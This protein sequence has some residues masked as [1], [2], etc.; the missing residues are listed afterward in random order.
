MKKKIISLILCLLCIYNS[1][2]F[3]QI[4]VEQVTQVAKN[5]LQERNIDKE[6]SLFNI[7]LEDV[8]QKNGAN[9]LYILNLGNKEGFFVLSASEFVAPIVGY[10]FDNEFQWQPAIRYYLDA[11][12][13][14]I[15]FE[16]KSKATPDA[17]VSNQWKHYLQEP[18]VS[19]KSRGVIVPPLITSTWNQNI[20]Y[21]TYC[22]W[23][24]RAMQ[25]FDGRVPNG[26][27]ALATAQLMNYWRHPEKG[28]GT[29]SYVHYRYGTQSANF[30]NQYYWDAMCDKPT[31]Y[32]NEIS[33]LA[34]HLG[35]AVSMNYAP[36]GS[37]A[38]TKK[39][40]EA[41]RDHFNYTDFLIW[42]AD[43]G[44]NKLSNELDSLRP[45]LMD[46]CNAAGCHAFLVDGY[47]EIDSSGFRFHFN[48]GWG[49]SADGYYSQTNQLYS[50]GYTYL[51]L[52]P[53][54]NYPV[55][56]QTYKRQTAT[57]GY[58][59]NG[60]TNKPY[61]SAP[62]CSW[63][64]AAP[65]VKEYT[66]SFS[67][68]ETQENIDVVTIYNGPTKNS[69]VAQSFSGTTLPTQKVK[70]VADSVL[71]TFTTFDATSQNTTHRG[72]L[73]NYSTDKPQQK[74]DRLTYL[75]T[76]NGYISS[77]NLADEKYTPWTSCTWNITPE[78]GSGFYGIF[79]NFDLAI[80]DFVD[81]Y[82]ANTPNPTFWKRYDRNTRPVIG[83][84]F[85][86]PFSK[87]QIKFISDNFEEG[88]GFKFQYLSLLGVDE[89]S[90]LDNLS[91][92]PNPASD[93]IN[94]SFTS[95]LENQSVV[96]RIVDIAG[97]EV[98]AT[99]IE[100][101]GGLSTTQIPVAHIAQGFYFLQLV[102]TT[103]KATHKIVIN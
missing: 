4:N 34:Y 66:F 96:C 24:S 27:V 42:V 85:F 12:S 73:M 5:F 94:L 1:N 30:T 40:A 98:F 80:G 59:T 91:I 61:Q 23:D 90:L 41:L 92:Y 38:D 57:Q 103:G 86:I 43:N 55:Q 67:R 53:A 102:T 25:G 89:H 10:S 46:G 44:G 11:Y 9:K 6:S 36:D 83:E 29:E 70:V 77:G 97:K 26:C 75:T 48:W 22:P 101:N 62:D 54:T 31:R 81:I 52:Q 21:N 63:I 78:N 16:E 28:I 60:S 50:G 19:S 65:G 87:V 64:I 93:C 74:C 3:A 84:A 35:V 99:N 95:A 100:Y 45:I 39:A 88:Y 20:Y 15:S 56:C 82:N 8:V 37:G 69:G 71:I 76:P 79:Q 2:T 68:L 18:F 51:G 32:T 72:F 58:I 14:Y 49:G 33:K 17:K 47:D 7:S 13:D